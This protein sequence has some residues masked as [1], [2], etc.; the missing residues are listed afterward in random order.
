M[1]HEKISFP[2]VIWKRNLKIF[3][4]NDLGKDLYNFLNSIIIA[5]RK[6]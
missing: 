4:S 2:D 5:L 3:K 1:N 6:T